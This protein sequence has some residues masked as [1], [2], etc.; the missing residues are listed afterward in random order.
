MSRLHP[1]ATQK[2]SYFEV[3]SPALISSYRLS[4]TSLVWI[5]VTMMIWISAAICWHQAKTMGNVLVGIMVRFTFHFSV[6]LQRRLYQS[7]CH[8][9]RCR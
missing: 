6:L 2:D 5:E 7:Y 3:V 8:A 1:D 9:W 4:L